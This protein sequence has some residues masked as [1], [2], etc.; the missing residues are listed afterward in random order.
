M[1][2]F[3]VC[4][5]RKWPYAYT[6]SRSTLYHKNG[7]RMHE[8]ASQKQYNYRM[9]PLNYAPYCCLNH[10]CCSINSCN[11]NP[12]AKFYHTHLLIYD[13]LGE[14]DRNGV[15]VPY[16]GSIHDAGCKGFLETFLHPHQ[17]PCMAIAF[18]HSNR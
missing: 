16:L 17:P 7:R 6:S 15:R 8:A 9:F 1:S 2:D 5:K 12:S 3:P 13:R 4:V 14:G 11:G 10:L 18:L